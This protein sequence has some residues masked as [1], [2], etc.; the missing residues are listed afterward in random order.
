MNHESGVPPALPG[1]TGP[2]FHARAEGQA[3]VQVQ[4]GNRSEYYLLYVR[5]EKL[6]EEVG[7]DKTT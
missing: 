7:T 2:A 6:I 3:Q 1:H 4:D 5:T